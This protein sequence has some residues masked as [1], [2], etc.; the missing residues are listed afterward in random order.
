MREITRNESQQV[1]GAF[2]CGLNPAPINW[3]GVAASALVGGVRGP[4]GAFLGGA[5]NFLGQA[6][7]CK[8]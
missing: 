8:F 7:V 4:L 2:S 1:G 3:A 5:G 6:W